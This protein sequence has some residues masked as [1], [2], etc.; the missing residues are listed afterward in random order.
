MKAQSNIAFACGVLFS[1]GLSISGMTRPGK[2]TAFLNLFGAW[3][4]TLLFVMLSAVAVYGLGFRWVIKR[5]RPIL[6]TQ[7]HVPAKGKIDAR[8]L[9]GAALFGTGWGLVGYCPGP[10][11]TALFCGRV[12][13]IL[14]TIGMVGGMWIFE[15]TTRPQ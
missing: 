9:I 13:P 14:F 8:L 12:P 7:F 6:D 11:V 15:K 4:P 2:V 5:S 3:D 1:I 10:A